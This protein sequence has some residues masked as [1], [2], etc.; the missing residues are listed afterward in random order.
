MGGNRSGARTLRGPNPF[1]G[2]KRDRLRF[3][4]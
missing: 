1:K 2:R 4:E 3:S